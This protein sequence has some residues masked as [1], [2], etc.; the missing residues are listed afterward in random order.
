MKNYNKLLVLILLLIFPTFVFAADGISVSKKSVSITEGAKVKITIKANNAAGRIDIASSD[1][2]VATVN[3]S[4]AFLDNDSKSITITGKKAGTTTVVV[5]LTDVTTYS[6]KDLSGGKININVTVKEKST[7]TDTKKED[8]KKTDTKKDEPKK[9]TPT[10]TKSSNSK[11]G[12]LTID[13]TG[14]TSSD[15]TN[16]SYSVNGS[17]SSVNIV[18]EPEDS[19]ATVSGTGTKNLLDGTNE[20]KV[21]VTAE[22]GSS[23]TYNI[24]INKNNGQYHVSDLNDYL[25]NNETGHI[26]LKD[27]DIVSSDMIQR[28]KDSGKSVTFDYY[29]GEK[30]LYSWIIDGRKISQTTSL[31]AT[32]SFEP[33]DMA[34][35]DKATNYTRGIFFRTRGTLN[36]SDGYILRIYGNEFKSNSEYKLY[37]YKD[38]MSFVENTKSSNGY[39]D[40]VPKDD[41]YFL[42]KADLNNKAAGKTSVLSVMTNPIFIILLLVVIVESV[43]LLLKM[44]KKKE[45]AEF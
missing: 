29:S 8:T 43:V 9:E 10:T 33:D 34:A 21:T 38:S 39:I 30:V 14:V 42:T 37:S 20:F 12:L 35:L 4:N 3:A 11:I 6:E 28:I 31:P 45:V 17:T 24:K 7:S 32:V 41:K 26:I 1:T 16:Y 5:K 13:G 22:D 19:K 18:V 25:N 36:L 27:N 44:R 2:S 40:L 23:S 15:G